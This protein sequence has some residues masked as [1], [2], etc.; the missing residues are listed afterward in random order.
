MITIAIS[1]V[2][3]DSIIAILQFI[4]QTC[5]FIVDS[6]ASHSTTSTGGSFPKEFKQLS[7]ALYR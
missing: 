3:F 1:E 2:H 6:L 4:K 7:T 5:F